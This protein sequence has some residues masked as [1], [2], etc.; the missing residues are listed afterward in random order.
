M[1]VVV[2]VEKGVAEDAVH[3][4]DKICTRRSAGE[5]IM[6]RQLERHVLFSELSYLIL[7]WVRVTKSTS[8]ILILIHMIMH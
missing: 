2:T 7:M 3:C 8:L 1:L 5:D 4:L 6:L